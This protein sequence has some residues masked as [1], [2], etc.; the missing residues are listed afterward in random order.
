[1]SWEAIL[2]WAPLLICGFMCLAMVF[3]C[4]GK[5]TCTMTG[6]KRDNSKPLREEESPTSRV[7]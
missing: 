6:D 1:M 5:G 3:G 4:T 2:L 7:S